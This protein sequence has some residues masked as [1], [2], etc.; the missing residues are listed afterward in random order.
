MKQKIKSIRPKHNLYLEITKGNPVKYRNRLKQ[1]WLIH[2]QSNTNHGE[3]G[4]EEDQAKRLLEKPQSVQ[5]FCW[6]TLIKKKKKKI[7]PNEVWY[8]NSKEEVMIKF[9]F[10]NFIRRIFLLIFS[11]YSSKNL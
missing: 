5:S 8:T 2:I 1:Q 6:S 10:L 3:R 4:K 9:Y 11:L 7:K